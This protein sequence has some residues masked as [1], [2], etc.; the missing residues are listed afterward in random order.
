MIYCLS[1]GSMESLKVVQYIDGSID[2]SFWIVKTK[3]LEVLRCISQSMSI[4][5]RLDFEVMSE[6]T[7]K[8]ILETILEDTTFNNLR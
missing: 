3:E 6:E 7:K 1:I 8:D 5:A 4:W 2:H